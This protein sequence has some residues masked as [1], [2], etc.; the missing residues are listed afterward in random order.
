[1]G[2]LRHVVPQ[3]ERAMAHENAGA[4][5]QPTRL[6]FA[7]GTDVGRK[8]GHNEDYVDAFRPSD[9]DKRRQ[10]GELFIVADGMGGHQAG[11]VASEN[12]VETA[13]REYY[14]SPVGDVSDALSDAIEKANSVGR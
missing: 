3:K 13:S 7:K 12:A 1:M 5:S 14:A 10:K 2:R 9:P 8:R 11:E 6:I 4:Q